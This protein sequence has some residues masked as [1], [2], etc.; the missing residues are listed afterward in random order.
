[1]GSIRKNP[2]QFQ[3]RRQR[4]IA[5]RRARILTAAATLFAQQGYASATIKEIADAADMAEGTLYNYFESKRDILLA[6]A[7]ETETP[8][9]AALQGA[10]G[11]TGRQGMVAMFEKALDIS[12]SQLPFTQAVLNEAWVDDDIL[13]QF[14]IVRLGQIHQLLV[15]YITEQVAAGLFRPIDPALG[16]QLLIGMFA[17]LILPALRGV[18]PLPS[19]KERRVLA[20][21]VVTFLLDGVLAR[22]EG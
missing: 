13:H 3:Q 19:Q 1:M 7:R 12:E 15:R 20:E 4:R 14:V 21:K 17:S 11:L 10:G 5:R 8:M 22:G 16:A 9:V 18:A 2:E 6:I